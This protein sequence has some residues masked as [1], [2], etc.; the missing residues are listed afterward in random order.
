MMRQV[1]TWAPANLDRYPTLASCIFIDG[2]SFLALALKAYLA[3]GKKMVPPEGRRWSEEDAPWGSA[4]D[5][6][7]AL[8]F[9]I[10]ERLRMAAM[11]A[12]HLSEPSFCEGEEERVDD[13]RTGAGQRPAVTALHPANRSRKIAPAQGLQDLKVT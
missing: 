4:Q 11:Q 3:A 6:F 12:G 1:E 7:D 13:R 2:D 10:S 9:Q 8:T 5:F